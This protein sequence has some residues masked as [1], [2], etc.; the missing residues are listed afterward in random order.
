MSVT[1][2]GCR[3]VTP[4]SRKG[5]RMINPRDQMALAFLLMAGACQQANATTVTQVVAARDHARLLHQL[6]APTRLG[7]ADGDTIHRG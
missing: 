2:C 4:C 7:F 3:A 1:I 6:Q 5:A